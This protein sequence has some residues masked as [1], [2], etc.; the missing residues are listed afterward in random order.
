V[1]G[2]QM[3]HRMNGEIV[4]IYIRDGSTL[5]KVRVDGSYFHVPLLLL[6]NARVGDHVIIDAGIALNRI[7][8]KVKVKQTPEP[9]L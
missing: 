3:D 6:M 2:Q 5:A 9:A 1:K 8:R 4:E 7:D